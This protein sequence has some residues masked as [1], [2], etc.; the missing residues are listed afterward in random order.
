[1]ST[2]LHT[3]TEMFWMNSD[4]CATKIGKKIQTITNFPNRAMTQKIWEFASTSE[5]DL[6]QLQYMQHIPSGSEPRCLPLFLGLRSTQS[7]MR[8]PRRSTDPA[9]T[10]PNTAVNSRLRP[11]SSIRN[12]EIAKCHMRSPCWTPQKNTACVSLLGTSGMLSYQFKYTTLHL[13]KFWC[14]MPYIAPVISGNVSYPHWQCT[15]DIDQ[16]F[17]TFEVDKSWPLRGKRG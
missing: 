6:N 10:N 9:T 11:Y 2:M 4:A 15:T 17:G 1:M 12:T 5:N 8:A 13:W 3:V 7:P 16:K 14:H